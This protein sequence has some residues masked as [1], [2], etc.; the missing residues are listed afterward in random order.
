MASPAGDG[1]TLLSIP[2]IIFRC[3]LG[4]LLV[5]TRTASP[6]LH[7]QYVITAWAKGVSDRDVRDLHGAERD[8]LSSA[9]GRQHPYLMAGL[10]IIEVAS[11]YV[12]SVVCYLRDEHAGHPLM[13]ALVVIGL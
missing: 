5:V 4:D 2:F 7:D 3:S 10:V 1:A 12:A 9:D 6:T 11:G 8:R 13:L